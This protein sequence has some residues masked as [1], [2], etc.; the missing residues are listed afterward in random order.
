MGQRQAHTLGLVD[1]MFQRKRHDGSSLGF[2]GTH[3][4]RVDDFDIRAC[5]SVATDAI[6]QF[7]LDTC[8]QQ[9]GGLADRVCTNVAPALTFGV[10]LQAASSL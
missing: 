7:M 10:L 4:N 6:L 1:V 3:V 8:C 2:V 5:R 9:Q